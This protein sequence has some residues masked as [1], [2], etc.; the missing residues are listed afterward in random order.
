LSDKQYDVI[1]AG[2]GTA[3]AATA[4]ALAR[5]DFKVA[6]I[7]PGKRQQINRKTPVDLRVSTLTPASCNLLQRLGVWPAIS[8]VRVSP[9]QSMRVWDENPDRDLLF[10]AADANL[11]DLG[12]VVENGLVQAVLWQAVESNE[13]VDLYQ[14]SLLQS[15]DSGDRSVRVRL[16]D[17]QRLRADLLVGADGARS[18]VREQFG[19]EVKLW[20]YQQKGLVC[21]VSTAESHQHTAW[22]RFLADGPLAFLPLAN[23]NCSIVWSQPSA[24]ADTRLAADKAEFENRLGQALHRR[25]GSVS[26]VSKR[27]VFPLRRMRASSYIGPRMVLLGDAAHVVHPLAGQGAN[28]G[29]LDAA[30]L[31]EVLCAARSEGESI[32]DQAVL[33]RYERWRVSDNEI[34]AEAMHNIRRLYAVELN[35]LTRMRQ[36]GASL[37]NQSRFVRGRLIQHASG[38]GGRVPE[39]V[40]P[41]L[42]SP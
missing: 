16:A 41:Q 1:V 20:D 11:E 27:A 28:L 13:S 34:V 5:R 8:E 31:V 36:V 18:A 14:E 17:G 22:Q 29:Y 24:I 15:A 30:A 7:D 35:P 26:L 38:F 9:F 32:A 3:G 4:L 12:H 19:I 39:L 10:R 6:M 40:K 23:G 2:G 21:V 37:L 42:V 25:L 33:R